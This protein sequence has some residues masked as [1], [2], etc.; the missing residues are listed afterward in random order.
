[1]ANG[2]IIH[3]RVQKELLKLG[4]EAY[5]QV[6][7]TPPINV[8]SLVRNIYK[9]GLTAVL[10]TNY[11][12]ANISILANEMLETILTQKT[13]RSNNNK[14]TKLKEF[15]QQQNTITTNDQMEVPNKNLLQYLQPEDQE[16]GLRILHFL[17]LPDGATLT[18]N[19]TSDN[20]EIQRITHTMFKHSLTLTKDEKILINN[21][22]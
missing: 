3:L 22:I 2:L 7:E 10:G 17:A 21:I 16:K 5:V 4:T 19:L 9:I 1:M 8:S 18:E 12:S 20:K 11:Q 13:Q 15:F 6:F 14:T